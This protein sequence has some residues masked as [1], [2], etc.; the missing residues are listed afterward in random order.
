M[1]CSSSYDVI[2][3]DAGG[4]KSKGSMLIGFKLSPSLPRPPWQACLR[5]HVCVSARVCVRAWSCVWVLYEFVVRV[6]VSSRILNMNFLFAFQ[7]ELKKFLCFAFVFSFRWFF[8][9]FLLGFFYLV[10]FLFTFRLFW[11]RLFPVNYNQG[12]PIKW[13]T[14]LKIHTHTRTHTLA[15]EIEFN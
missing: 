3:Y 10:L 9:C 14:Q 15:R 8:F 7:R 2:V 13:A 1:S 5:V 4:Q 11:Q 6:L 12:I